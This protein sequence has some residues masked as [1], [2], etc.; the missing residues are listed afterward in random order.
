MVKGGVLE[1][2]GEGRGAGGASSRAGCWRGM[3]KGGAL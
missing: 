1:G 3:L 2:H